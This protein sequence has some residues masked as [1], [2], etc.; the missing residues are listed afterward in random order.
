MSQVDDQGLGGLG[1]LLPEQVL[2]ALGALELLEGGFP[3]LLFLLGL[4][5][6]ELGQELDLMELGVELAPLG[7]VHV[8]QAQEGRPREVLAPALAGEHENVEGGYLPCFFS[9]M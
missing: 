4:L 8:L 7:D 2:R 6:D 5:V 1:V 3:N 9:N